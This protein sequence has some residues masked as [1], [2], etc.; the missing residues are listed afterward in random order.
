MRVY[1]PMGKKLYIFSGDDCYY[2]RVLAKT[3]KTDTL[4][5]KKEIKYIRQ[6]LNATV[7]HLRYYLLYLLGSS[8]GERLS[9]P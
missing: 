2:Q 6:L 8:F 3:P 9:S 1:L 4:I 7:S 5:F